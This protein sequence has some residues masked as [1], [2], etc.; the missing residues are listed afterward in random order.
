MCQRK[1][2]KASCIVTG[3]LDIYNLILTSACFTFKLESL[4][5]ALLEASEELIFVPEE[6]TKECT[7]I[8]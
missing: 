7:L 3:K 1:H 8:Y 4:F 5:Y 6:L 2:L